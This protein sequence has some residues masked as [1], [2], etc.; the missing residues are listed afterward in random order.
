MN[1]V[2][3]MLGL[4]LDTE[5]TAVWKECTA[6]ALTKGKALVS[7]ISDIPDLSKIESGRM[8]LICL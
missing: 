7:L 8:D 4:L 2:V 5:E 3:G 6:T 1:G